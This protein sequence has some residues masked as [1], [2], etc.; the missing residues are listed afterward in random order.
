MC[1]M[2]SFQK[3]AFL[4]LACLPYVFRGKYLIWN[5]NLSRIRIQQK[6]FFTAIKSGGTCTASKILSSR[7]AGAKR[8]KLDDPLYQ[9]ENKGG[10]QGYGPIASNYVFLRMRFIVLEYPCPP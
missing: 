1:S 8:P 3:L 10:Y 2:H 9:A 6:Y 4:V 7:P 5:M